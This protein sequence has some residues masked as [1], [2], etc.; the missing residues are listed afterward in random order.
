M[1]RAGIKKEN[2]VLNTI[3]GYVTQRGIEDEGCPFAPR[4]EKR[5]AD[6]EA[7]YGMA[8]RGPAHYAACDRAYAADLPERERDR[9]KGAAALRP[10]SAA[11]NGDGGLLP[12]G[13]T[14]AL[15]GQPE[16]KELESL[17]LLSV[18]RLFKRYRGQK[19]VVR[20]LDGVDLV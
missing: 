18:E 1:P 16:N 10:K 20:A 2:V 7:L 15:A 14:G 6:C 3:P 8:E 11:S 4:C 5:N 13:N 12:I 19:S 9:R 17:P